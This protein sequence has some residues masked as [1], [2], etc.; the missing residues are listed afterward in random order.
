MAWGLKFPRSSLQKNLLL[1]R[2]A[3]ISIGVLRP[4]SQEPNAATASVADRGFKV[5]AVMGAV[6]LIFAPLVAALAFASVAHT[7]G[8]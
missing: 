3:F 4:L 2:R 6:A 8:G 7:R 5:E 1:L